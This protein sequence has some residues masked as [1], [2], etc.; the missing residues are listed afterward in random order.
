M[1]SVVG[2]NL[3]VDVNDLRLLDGT[4]EFN[5]VLTDFPLVNLSISDRGALK[6]LTII[7][8]SSFF[9]CIL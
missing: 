7:V 3:S 4:V 5:Y 9:F 8:D 2:C 6:S 1:Y